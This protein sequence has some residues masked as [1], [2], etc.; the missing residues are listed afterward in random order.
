MVVMEQM[1][2]FSQFFLTNPM[3][4]P[5]VEGHVER[6]IFTLLS[7]RQANA[8]NNLLGLDGF[9]R[10]QQVVYR[11]A[12]DGCKAC[13]SVRVRVDD[14]SLSASQK[15]LSKFNLRVTSHVMPPLA[16]REQYDLFRA[17]L[18]ARHAS[19][20]MADMGVADYR[21][22]VEGS[23]VNTHIVEYRLQE[24]LIAAALIDVVSDGYSMVYSFYNPKLTRLSLGSWMI[25]DHIA[26][27]RADKLQFIYLG[28]WIK[29]AKKMDYKRRFQPLE[30]YIDDRW[31]ELS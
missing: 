19:G 20:G 7:G 3:P 29:D 21:A 12:C 2:K 5:Y 23:P 11:P 1:L 15:R 30:Y 14:F 16:T 31:Q 27:A 26:R 18:D 25:L 4:C 8:I 22:M 13:I 24:T 10:S 17:Y 6:K 9:R 28:Y